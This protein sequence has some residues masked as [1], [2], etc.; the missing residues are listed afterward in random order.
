MTTK[1]QAEFLA[2]GIISDQTQVSAADADHL[3]I[4]DAS[5]NSL[6]KALVST[7][8]SSSAAD[9]ITAGD[10]AVTIS[11]SSGNITIDNGSSDDDIIFKGT[12]GG[13]DIT[14][15]TLDM[16]SSG[17]ALFNSSVFV[18]NHLYLVDNKKAIFGA[19]EDL[20]ITSD[21]TDGEISATNNLTIDVAGELKLDA[22][23]GN[24]TLQDGGTAIGQFQL[25]DT[26]HLKLGSKVSD[27]DIFFFGN[28]GGSNVNALRLDMSEAGAAAFNSTVTATQFIGDVVNGQTTENTVA[29]DDVIAFYDTSAGAIRKT[30]ISNLP[31]SGGGGSSAADDITT[32]DAAVTI[33]TSTG[34]ITLDSP[35]D[36]ILDAGGD[37]WKFYEDGNA[38][39][40]IKHESHGVDFLLNTTDEDWRFKGSDGGSTITA[41]HLDIS[42]AGA[43]TFSGKITADAGI[44]IDNFNIDGTTIALSSGDITVDAAGRIDL[45][46]DDNGEV[47]LFDGSS[48]YGQFKDDSD[49]LKI[50]SM[51]SDA[52]MLFVGNDGGSEVTALTLDMSEAG[53]ATFNNNVGIGSTPVSTIR[54]DGN[55]TE[56]ALQVGRAAMLFSDTGLTTDLQNNSHLNN[57]DQ[58]V[59]MTGTSGGSLYVQYNGVHT[60]YTAAAVAAPNVQSM[61]AR[62]S[63]DISGN[64]VVQQNITAYGSPSDIKL[65]E[66]IKVIDNPLDKVKQLKGITYDLKSDGNRLTGLIAQD[67]EKVLPEAVYT[68]KTIANEKEGEVA[69]EHLAIR[70]GNTV[71]LLVEAIKELEARVKELEAK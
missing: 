24:I 65:K 16:S 38:V 27:A 70:Y 63:L 26:N 48:Q 43:A 11:T 46:A 56:H 49:R 30:A 32:G 59:A 1:V 67:L 68:S 45:S 2:A 34:T 37:D 42:E 8:S 29:N 54:N 61:T 21:G 57:S 4:F 6:K 62:M 44:D 12:D 52:D 35:D 58:R 17:Q 9:D 7:I 5:D 55:A 19:G 60:W 31:S 23:G 69:E 13:S 47:R 51:I 3:L 18:G 10:G 41:L 40:E 53:A 20:F 66:N 14:A 15:L 50:Q 28:D 25:N 64:L 22:D 39:F 71:G 36:I 33:A